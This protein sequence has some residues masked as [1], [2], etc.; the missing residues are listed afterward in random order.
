MVRDLLN[1]LGGTIELETEPG[2]G[3]TFTV[4]LPIRVEAAR[5]A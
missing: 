2:S 3:S 4:R 1:H 5:P